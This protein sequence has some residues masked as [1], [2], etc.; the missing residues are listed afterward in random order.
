VDPNH[1]ID[2]LNEL[3]HGAHVRRVSILDESGGRIHWVKRRTLIG[4]QRSLHYSGVASLARRSRR[5]LR[6]DFVTVMYHSVPDV[7]CESFIDPEVSIPAAT[8]ERHLKVLQRHANVIPIDHALAWMRGEGELPPRAA[9]LT[10]DDGYLDNVKVVAPLL[11]Q[12]GMPATMFIATGYVDRE[13]P[14]WVDQLYTAFRFRQRYELIVDDGGQRFDV[15]TDRAA[16]RAYKSLTAQLLAG[17]VARRRQLLDEVTSSLDPSLSCPPLTARWQDLRQLHVDYPEIEL[18]LHGH[19]HLDLQALPLGEAL[20]EVHR[21]Q[22]RFEAEMGFRAR[23][24][25]YP[26]GRCSPQLAS[27]MAQYGIEA[28]FRTQPSL[29]TDR[30]TDRFAIPRFGAERS[31]VDLRLWTDGVLPGLGQRLFGAVADH[32]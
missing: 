15:S 11:R 31:A 17:D 3:Q 8:F 22:S 5:D 6:A 27:S 13:E 32:E 12:Y 18:G 30:S 20:L 2:T 25:S 10:F 9:V 24:M 1:S 4:L 28:A 19:D 21:S 26:Y 7:E 16:R 23:F 14:Q 29:R